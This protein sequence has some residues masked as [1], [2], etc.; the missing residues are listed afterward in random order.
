MSDNYSL[1]ISTVAEQ[2]S[3]YI[4]VIGVG[5]AGTNAVNHMYNKGITGVDFIVCNTDRQSLENSP[6]PTKIKIGEGGLGAGNRPEVAKQAAIAA[7][8]EIKTVL[9]NNTHMLFIT[10]GMGGGTGTGA[11]PEIAKIAK[12]I[13]IDDGEDEILVVA[14]VTIPFSFEG[15]TRKQQAR[16]GIENLKQSVDAI[17]VVNTDSL[18]KRGN[19]NMHQAFA[20]ADDVLLTAAKGISEIMT[21]NSYIHVDFRD[22]QSVMAHSGVAL[23][24]SG[25]GEGEDRA[26]KAIEAAATSELLNDNDLSGTKNILFYVSYSSKE[27]YILQT[28]EIE[29]ITN[30]IQ[31]ITNPD[32]DMIWGC[33]I[34]DSLEEKLSI[35]L[36]ATGFQESP[37]KV[38][39]HR[40]INTSTITLKPPVGQETVVKTLN[41]DSKPFSAP[42]KVETKQAKIDTNPLEDK[43]S[44]D[45]VVT[46]KNE[47]KQEQSHKTKPS[48]IILLSDDDEPIQ[49]QNTLFDNSFARAKENGVNDGDVMKLFRQS[50]EKQKNNILSHSEEEP[51][52]LK[53]ITFASM[54]SS[55]IEDN[56]FSAAQTAEMRSERIARVNAM[57]KSGQLDILEKLSP[58]AEDFDQRL[59]EQKVPSSQMKVNKEGNIIVCENKTL[60]AKVD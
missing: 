14:V 60:D 34:D 24:G 29:E 52:S 26:R 45:F 38:P 46:N 7:A 44:M 32:V 43:A 48:N 51:K 4:K 49:N 16:V 30:Y 1:D 50:D 54:N 31:E 55:S 37:M 39:E 41:I 17:I 33:G 36:V 35:T 10:A 21:A 2:Q 3:S 22:V 18:K 56:A 57:L 11:S 9:S 47:A 12:E 8:E 6:I 27:E 42:T 25:V 20:L 5:G 53:E 13:E 59:S 40:N 23:M 19:M 15:P 58:M 28:D